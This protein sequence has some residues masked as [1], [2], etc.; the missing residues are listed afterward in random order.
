M[1]LKIGSRTWALLAACAVLV[2]A[3][4]VSA[5]ASS[6][7]NTLQVKVEDGVTRYST[8][9]GK[10]WSTEAPEGVTRV[11]DADGKVTITRGTAP[12]EGDGGTE[13]GLSEG[14]PTDISRVSSLLVKVED[15]VKRYS[16]DGGKTWSAKPPR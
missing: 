5:S 2:A 9:D 7:Y 13:E 14:S 11:T 3:G 1:T 8:D 16:T 4:A 10:T 12:A 6:P 15:G